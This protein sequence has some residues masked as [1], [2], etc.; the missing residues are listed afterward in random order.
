MRTRACRECSTSLCIFL[1]FVPSSSS[2]FKCCFCVGQEKFSKIIWSCFVY[3]MANTKLLLVDECCGELIMWRVLWVYICYHALVRLVWLLFV[4]VFCCF[5]VVVFVCVCVCVCFG[6]V[7]V[8]LE[9]YLL[10]ADACALHLLLVWML[11]TYSTMY[12]SMLFWV[13]MSLFCFNT[14]DIAVLLLF[15]HH[16][17]FTCVEVFCDDTLPEL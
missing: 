4:I 13:V 17:D 12:C 15:L 2:H 8:L 5:V 1:N 3:I 10:W 6:G 7:F 14:T 11:A 9:Q 16:H